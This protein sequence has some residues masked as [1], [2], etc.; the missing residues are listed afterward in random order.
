MAGIDVSDTDKISP[1]ITKR[2]VFLFMNFLLIGVLIHLI[3][4]IESMQRGF[5]Q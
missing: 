3:I 2:V 1:S 4:W 5:C